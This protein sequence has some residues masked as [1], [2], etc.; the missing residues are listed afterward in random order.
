MNLP[1]ALDAM[2]GDYAP[3]ETVAGALAAAA[4]GVPV[5]LV[6]DE[7]RLR[8]ELAEQGGELPV[9]HAPEV[10][11]MHAAATEVRRRRQASINVAM[12]LVKENE[13]GAAVSMGH[14]GATMASALFT[15]GRIGGF[16]RPAILAEIPSAAPSGRVHLIDAGANADVRP[17]HLEQFARLGAAYAE[18][19]SG[20]ARPRVGL[21]SIGEEASKGNQLVLE[22]HPLL[23]R[24]DLNF[25][26]NVEGRDLL[27]D[28][29]DVV[30][31]DGFTGNV[32]LKLAE[33]EARILFGWI[34]E[35]LSSSLKAKLGGLLVRDALKRLAARMDPA[36][37]GAMPLLGVRGPVFIGH[38]ASDRRAVT[39]ALLRA[40][41]MAGSGLVEFL[42]G[43]E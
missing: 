40:H 19:M 18:R 32:A 26:G 28:V 5:V 31:T 25:I 27:A 1:V 6:G 24:L 7:E 12:R 16:E 36:E 15:L 9:V 17:A 42:G 35:A 21:L 13:A 30:V 20:V 38:G 2:G 4:A 29:A 41:K 39:N 10:I 3:R 43:V 33:G 23:H 8:R 34:K 37:Y 22:A 14:S 11:E